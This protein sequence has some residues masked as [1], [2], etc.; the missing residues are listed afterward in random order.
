MQNIQ[1]ARDTT[2]EQAPALT[3]GSEGDRTRRKHL[4]QGKREQLQG[5][6]RKTVLRNWTTSENSSEATGAGGGGLGTVPT[7][8]MSASVR[9]APRPRLRVEM[10]RSDERE[11]T[12]VEATTVKQFRGV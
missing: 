7:E 9:K 5:D 10:L 11:T 1:Q 3:S 6:E 4:W 8:V 12:S 2:D